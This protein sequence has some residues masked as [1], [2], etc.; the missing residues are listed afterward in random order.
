MHSIDKQLAL[1]F[2][3]PVPKMRRKP[4]SAGSVKYAKYK[5]KR[6]TLCTDCIRDIHERGQA[7]APLPQVVMW[8][9]VTGNG[10]VDLLCDKHRHIRQGQEAER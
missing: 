5:P 4:F 3:E 8:K 6:R 10:D 1:F 2:V 7:V 9:R